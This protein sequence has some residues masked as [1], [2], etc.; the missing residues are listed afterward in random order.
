MSAQWTGKYT[1]LHNDDRVTVEIDAQN[2]QKVSGFMKDSHQT[3]YIDGNIVDGKLVGT[4]TEPSLGVTFQLMAVNRNEEI[5]FTLNLTLLDEKIET[6]F[7]AYREGSTSRLQSTITGNEQAYLPAGALRNP[8]LRGAWVYQETYN[9]GS[10]ADFMG[11]NF[12][13]TIIFYEDGRVGEGGSSANMSGSY[14]SAGSSSQSQSVIP[15]LSW[16]TMGD[17]IFLHYREG[18]NQ[19]DLH[20][21][22]YYIEN[23][24]LLLTSTDGNKLLLIRQ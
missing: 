13:E 23:D 20:L 14:Y 6:S 9:S 1:A 15:G 18:N 8:A 24:K 17:Q 5:T 4:A 7:Q 2:P 11:A 21:G 16:Y 10:G 19:Q 12:S 22:K 3:F